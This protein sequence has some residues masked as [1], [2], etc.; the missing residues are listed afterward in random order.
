[1]QKFF[2]VF[3]LIPLFALGAGCGAPAEQSYDVPGNDAYAPVETSDA[4]DESGQADE[5]AQSESVQ[6][7]SAGQVEAEDL[8]TAEGVYTME[9]VAKHDNKDDCWFVIDG[10]VYDVTEYSK[11]PGQEA[12]FEG[13]GQDATDLFNT[14][15]MGSGTPH[16]EKARGYLTNWEIGTIK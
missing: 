9:E 10:K 7:Q 4:F 8:A 3:L 15:P 1:M 12:I 6:D 14:R 13:C 16:S 11:H 2:Y 5:S